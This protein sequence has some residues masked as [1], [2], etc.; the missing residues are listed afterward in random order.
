MRD[1]RSGDIATLIRVTV[2][3]HTQS[4]S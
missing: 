4:S 2:L 1:K 3:L